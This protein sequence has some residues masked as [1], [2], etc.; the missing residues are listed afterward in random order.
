MTELRKAAMAADPYELTHREA[1]LIGKSGRQDRR[2]AAADRPPEAVTMKSTPF[3]AQSQGP[4]KRYE[5]P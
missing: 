5:K 3:S 2:Q 1:P 4:G